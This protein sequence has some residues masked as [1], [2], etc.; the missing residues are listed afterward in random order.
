M[1]DRFPVLRSGLFSGK[2]Q[3][4]RSAF[5]YNTDEDF[6]NIRF[7]KPFLGLGLKCLSSPQH[8]LSFCFFFFFSRTNDSDKYLSWKLKWSRLIL[9]QKEKKKI[10]E[11]VVFFFFGVLICNSVWLKALITPRSSPHHCLL[12]V[13]DGWQCC[14]TDFT[15]LYKWCTDPP[16]YCEV[17]CRHAEV[18]LRRKLKMNQG[19][20]LNAYTVW[21]SEVLLTSPLSWWTNRQIN[22]ALLAVGICLGVYLRQRAILTPACQISKVV[23]FIVEIF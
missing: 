20:S 2:W 22:N 13:L 8:E 5:E 19:S 6:S 15:V 21:N 23:Y 11:V 4:E 16:R 3:E 17:M 9:P 14:F 7:C 10:S 18:S 12:I 1:S